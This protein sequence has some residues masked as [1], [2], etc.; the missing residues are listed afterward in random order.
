MVL[1]GAKMTHASESGHWY[2]RDGEPMYEVRAKDGTMRPA[3]LRD[4]RKFGWYPGVTTITRCAAAPQLE[5]WKQDQVLMAAL[6][7]PRI[8]G[9]TN[10]RLCER[11]LQDSQEQA[12][13]AAKVGTEYHAAIQSHYEGTP[14]PEELW[15]M[16]KG[17]TETILFHFGEQPWIPEK[18]CA[19]PLGFGTKADLSCEAACLDF[20]GKD[21]TKDD[22]PK[23]DTYD[24]HHMQ[25]AATREARRLS[26]AKCAIVY[27]SRTVPGLAKVCYVSEEELARGW[28]MFRA[29]L[30]YWKANKGYYPELW[31]PEQVAA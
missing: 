19:H 20:K 7:L 12:K 11:I 28:D 10:E 15:P 26:G 5:R 21:F 27:V 16:V 25:L 8:D 3:T 22:L 24:A 13:E 2:S 18:A 30:A 31:K 17:V 23:L 29:L 6:T 14:P 4:A 1:T 9:E